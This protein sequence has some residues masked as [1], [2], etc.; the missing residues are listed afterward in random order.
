[1][2]RQT[3]TLHE[4]VSPPIF[5]RRFLDRLTRTRPAVLVATHLPIIAA[6]TALT[7]TRMSLVAALSLTVAGS[8]FWT[9]SEYWIHRLVFHF[10]PQGTFGR[11]LHHV[12]HGAHHDHP[13]DPDRL[14]MPPAANIPGAAAFLALFWVVIGFPYAYGFGSGFLIGYV[15][16]DLT[17]YY[18]HHARP[19]GGFPK[20]LRQLHM[21]HHFQDHTS[22]FGVSSPLWDK[23]FGTLPAG[24]RAPVRLS[25]RRCRAACRDRCP[26]ATDSATKRRRTRSRKD[27]PEEGT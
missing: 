19:K 6:L 7:F 12:I 5:R 10:E 21:R 11:K 2:P 14:L 3:T 4:E 20:Y 24:R 17:H 25:S 8:V 13:Q 1:M 16:Y 26:G 18:L 23:V 9:F 15:L 22:A 27:D